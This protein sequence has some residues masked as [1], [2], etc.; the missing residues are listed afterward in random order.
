MHGGS[1]T[2]GNERDGLVAEG[3]EP[4]HPAPARHQDEPAGGF[5]YREEVKSLDFEALKRD[6]TP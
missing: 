5:N 3:A 4:R 1:T 6:L 2:T